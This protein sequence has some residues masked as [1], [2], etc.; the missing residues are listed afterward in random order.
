MALSVVK[1]Y[2]L[3]RMGQSRML[4]IA[5][6]QILEGKHVKPIGLEFDVPA[7]GEITPKI[8]SEVKTEVSM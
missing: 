7:L 6:C 1:S 3:F 2:S 4:I 5:G 8:T